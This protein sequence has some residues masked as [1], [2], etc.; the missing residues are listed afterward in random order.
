M[1]ESI[2]RQRQ[3]AGHGGEKKRV[4]IR[5]LPLGHNYGNVIQA[6]ALQES[7]RALGS[8]PIVDVSLSTGRGS[9]IPRMTSYTLKRALMR[10]GYSKPAWIQSVIDHELHRFVADRISTAS[11]YTGPG[12]VDSRFLDTVD[13]FIVGSDQV[14]RAPYGDVRS[15][16]FD[17]LPDADQRP[18]YSY[19]AS[20]G[21]DDLAEYDSE[22]LRDS[23][24]LVRRFSGVSVRETTG[25]AIARNSWGIDA[26]QH[27][28][29]TMLLSRSHYTNLARQANDPIDSGSVIRYVLDP[30]ASTETTARSVMRVLGGSPIQMLTESPDLTAYRNNPGRFIRPSMEAWLGAFCNARFVVTDSFHGTVFSIINN[31]PFISIINQG[32]GASRF[33]DLLKIFGL[34]ERM[35]APGSIPSDSVVSDPIDWSA[36]N[37]RLDLERAKALLF[38]SQVLNGI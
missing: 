34:E 21:R 6:Y 14:W 19:A 31:V 4:L 30:S 3:Y 9:S 10:V 24:N 33:T 38:L 37:A 13:L 12:V 11:L 20:F 27:V 18:R 8:E 25:I 28:D 2:A 23:R 1:P 29:P 16:L 22:L 35:I 7:L 26:I 32:R 17:F 36:V 5:T 15:Y